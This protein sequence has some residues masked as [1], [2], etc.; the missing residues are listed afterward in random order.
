M[1][2]ILFII[3]LLIGTH[4]FAQKTIYIYNLSSTNFDIGD[5]KTMDNI[6]TY[7][8]FTS[9]PSTGMISIPA[10]T[11]YILEAD[12]VS[13]TKFPFYSPLTTPTIDFW[14]RQLVPGGSG[15]N[16][17]SHLVANVYG[18]PQILRR[19]KFQVGR[20][21]FLGGG[22]FYPSEANNYSDM[23]I[24]DGNVIVT[25]DIIGSVSGDQE[26]DGETYIIISD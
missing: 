16:L 3:I 20:N 2:K 12:P 6:T 10:G 14:T 21:G 25:F 4:V 19:I 24:L 15:S 22:S 13:T 8:I 18:N 26:P 5:I 9:N 17:P 11:T 23:F 1:K 7:P